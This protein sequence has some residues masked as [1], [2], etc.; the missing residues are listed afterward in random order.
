MLIDID[1]DINT[2]DIFA[3]TLARMSQGCYEETASVEFK[4]YTE[5]IQDLLVMGIGAIT[6][7]D[8]L[9]ASPSNF[10]EPGDKCSLFVP[11]NF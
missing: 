7:Q 4:L 3:R 6:L 1:I 5:R 11:Y 2:R 9:D 10:G 8:P